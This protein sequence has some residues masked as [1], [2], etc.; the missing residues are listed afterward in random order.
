[1]AFLPLAR[2][3]RWPEDEA[4]TDVQVLLYDGLDELDAVAPLEILAAAGLDVTTMALDAPATVTGDHGL[5][6]G[7]DAGLGEAPTL[8]IVPGGGWLTGKDSGARAAIA[9]GRL[10]AWIADC[11]ARGTVVAS[12]CTG[13]LMLAAAGLLDGRPAATHHE[14]YEVLATMGADV[15]TDARVVDDGELLSAG[16]V[17]SGID[18]SIHLVG[19]M[20]G[21]Q[22]AVDA[23]ARIEHE[24]RG[25][26]LVTERGA[27][28]SAESTI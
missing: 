1:M 20:L 2:Q 26:L 3:A 22:A 19:R 5:R 4:M 23:A 17:T 14:A 9:D 13:S 11:H 21:E 16:G 12:V 7:V 8:L 27:T 15:R 18:L 10:P 28:F 6:M 24:V 25:P